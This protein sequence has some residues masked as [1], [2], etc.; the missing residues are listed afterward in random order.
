MRETTPALPRSQKYHGLLFIGDPHLAAT[1]P[2]FR[3]DDYRRT[4]LDKLSFCLDLSARQNSTHHP[5]R[6]V[7]SAPKQPQPSTSGCHGIVPPTTTL[8]PGRQSR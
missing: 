1:P 5:G 7:S 4:I 6:P 2:G 8:G 3:I